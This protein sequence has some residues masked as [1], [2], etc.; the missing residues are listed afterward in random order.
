[1]SQPSPPNVLVQLGV[2]NCTVIVGFSA[3]L[4]K[5]FAV[6]HPL[7]VWHNGENILAWLVSYIGREILDM[8][9]KT[10][11]LRRFLDILNAKPIR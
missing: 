1:M 3:Q 5:Y 10:P 6:L 7:S 4:L 2:N 8:Q 9:E 11:V